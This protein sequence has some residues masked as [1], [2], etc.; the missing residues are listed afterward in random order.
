MFCR[1]F[2][3]PD[4]LG[5]ALRNLAERFVMLVNGRRIE[6]FQAHNRGAFRSRRF[7]FASIKS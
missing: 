6:L 1:F 2:M 5:Q 3:G 7:L 4:E